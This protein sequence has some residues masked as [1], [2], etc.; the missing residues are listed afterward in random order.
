MSPD[1][2]AS[3]LADFTIL[4]DLLNKVLAN[5]TYPAKKE[6]LSISAM[7]KAVHLAARSWAQETS[8]DA[9]SWTQKT[10]PG[11]NCEENAVEVFADHFSTR[12]ECDICKRLL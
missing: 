6:L 1:N 7:G 5:K 3:A 9:R 2:K 4:R 8:A 10:S 11:H 12:Y